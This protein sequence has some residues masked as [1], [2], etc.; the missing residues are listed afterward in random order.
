MGAE[1]IETACLNAEAAWVDLATVAQGRTIAR[2]LQAEAKLSRALR[3]GHQGE[4]AK[5][6]LEAEAAGVDAATIRLETPGMMYHLTTC[7][8]RSLLQ[9]SDDSVG[10][11]GARICGTLP[12]AASCHAGVIN[13]R[14]EAM[15][16]H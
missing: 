13:C 12:Q 1:K 16:M 15:R 11:C 5:A 14:I 9:N 4:I 7:C 2:R 10:Q 8:Q 6:C 3:R